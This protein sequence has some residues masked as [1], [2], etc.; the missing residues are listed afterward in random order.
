MNFVLQLSI[1]PERYTYSNGSVTFGFVSYNAISQG[2]QSVPQ[3]CIRLLHLTQ[4]SLSKIN[5]TRWKTELENT[6]SGGANHTTIH[7]ILPSYF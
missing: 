1:L 4:M 5:N 3:F 2:L 6:E 7:S